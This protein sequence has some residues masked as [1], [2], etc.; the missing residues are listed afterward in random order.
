MEYQFTIK[1]KDGE[2]ARA[3]LDLLNSLE[4]MDFIETVSAPVLPASKQSA[5]SRK[6]DF[7]A[8]AGIW[9]GRKISLESIR[10]EAWRRTSR[11]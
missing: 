4:S 10:R 2:K 9:A 3:L 7:F 6:A 8:L 1:V 11:S 5:K